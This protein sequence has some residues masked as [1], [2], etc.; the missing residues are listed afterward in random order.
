[1]DNQGDAIYGTCLG[2]MSLA[3]TRPAYIDR[4]LQLFLKVVD[5]QPDQRLNSS[6]TT[7]SSCLLMLITDIYTGGFRTHE[8]WPQNRTHPGAEYLLDR[9][10]LNYTQEEVEGNLDIILRDRTLQANEANSTIAKAAIFARFTVLINQVR[11]SWLESY[12]INVQGY[13]TILRKSKSFREKWIRASFIAALVRVR[14]Y[15]KSV[16]EN[17]A[18]DKLT[19]RKM[20]E[21]QELLKRWLYDPELNKTNDLMVK[22]HVLVSENLIAL[23]L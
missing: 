17:F 20:E 13:D 11:P 1:M 4:F 12:W 23:C 19:N 2:M 15:A 8:F 3:N 21:W 7:F 14:G 6:T 5:I 22:H 16:S 18:K 10:M 9:S